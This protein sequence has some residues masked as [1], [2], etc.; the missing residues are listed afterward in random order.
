MYRVAHTSLPVP[1][2]MG[3]NVTG[4]N[5]IQIQSDASGNHLAGARA[6]AAS[7]NDR[8]IADSEASTSTGCAMCAVTS[9]LAAGFTFRHQAQARSPPACAPHSAGPKYRQLWGAHSS[10]HVF[11][12]ASGI[13]M[14][15]R[16][17]EKRSPVIQF[18]SG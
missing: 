1:C 10:G 12:R 6:H 15:G 5:G 11:V 9:T 14:F 2:E 4:C 7:G 13:G 3:P 17:G 8:Q 18:S 16:P